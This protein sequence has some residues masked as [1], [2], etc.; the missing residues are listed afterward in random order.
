MSELIAIGG[1]IITGLGIAITMLN[2]RVT[3]IESS[4][5]PKEVFYEFEKRFQLICDKIDRLYDE[6]QIVKDLIKPS[7][8]DGTERRRGG[9]KDE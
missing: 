5:L 4:M 2:H 9:K 6:I 7:H 1:I 3:K 8:W